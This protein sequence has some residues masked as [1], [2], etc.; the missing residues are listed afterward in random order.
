MTR[1]KRYIFGMSVPGL[2]LGVLAGMALGTGGYTYHYGEG[3]SYLSNDPKACVNCH[4]MR[5]HYDGWAKSTHHAAAACNDCHTP[6]DLLGKYYVKAENGFFHSKAFTL[7]NYRD[8]LIIRPGN[9]R[10]LQASCIHCHRELVGGILGHGPRDDGEAARCVHCH[11]S[12]GHGPT[13]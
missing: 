3:F 13:R 10:V 1:R 5:E 7:Q 11:A 8:P 9:S 12:V 6:H 2:A 4:L